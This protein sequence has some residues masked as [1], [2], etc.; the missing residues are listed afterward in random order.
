MCISKK[1]SFIVF[2]LNILLTLITISKISVHL[3]DLMF[4][5]VTQKR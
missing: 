5:L 2:F 1:A 3:G 4:Y